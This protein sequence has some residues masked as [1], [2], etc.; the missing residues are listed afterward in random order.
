MIGAMLPRGRFLTIPNLLSLS[1]LALLPVF[2][3]SL[4]TPGHMRLVLI[5][6][7]Y[8]VVSD[9]LDGYLAR[10]LGQVSE[11]GRVLDPLSDKLAVA[12]ALVFCFFQRGLPWWMLALVLA[13]DAGILLLAPLVS[14]RVGAM[15]A[16]LLSGRLAALSLAVLAGV[17]LLDLDP[18]KVPALAAA[19][20]LLLISSVQYGLRLHWHAD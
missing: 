18:V 5:L 7:L 4:V 6:V 16:S 20:F 11:W 14:R 1:R 15:P 9:L 2:I 10:R 12:A 3:W 8:A 19:V 13:R 17:Y